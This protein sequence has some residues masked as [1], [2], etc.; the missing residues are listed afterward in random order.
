MRNMSRQ[1]GTDLIEIPSE[2]QMGPA[3]LRLNERQRLFVC[4]LAVYGGDQQ[5]AYLYAGYKAKE[6]PS[7]A[8]AASRLA[9]AE[10]IVKAIQEE[11]LRRIN[12]ATLLAVSTLVEQASFRNA[13]QK[14]RNKAACDILDRT[15]FNARTEHRI[16]IKD[17]RTT[18]E[19]MES[20]RQ[21]AEANG[22]DASKL[23]TP[24]VIDAEATEVPVDDDLK[25][26]F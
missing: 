18:A 22:L 19:L 25:D 15:N 9:N 23:L 1:D 3:M 24:P 11:T 17:D 4:A 16:I 10:D 14:L 6:G 13:D 5:A 26:L 7:A 2:D 8:A 20:I 12:S 21:L